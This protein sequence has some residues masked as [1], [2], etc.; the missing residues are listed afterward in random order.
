MNKEQVKELFEDVNFIRLIF[1]DVNGVLKNVEL[2]ISQLDKVLANEV[3]FDG[4]SI[5]GFTRIEESDMYLVPDL[6]TA[7]VMP[8]DL[9][10]GRKIGIMFCTAKTTDQKPFE[11]DP[12]NVLIRTL[13]RAK[14]LGFDVMV[15]PEPEF[16]LIKEDGEPND[17]GGYF[18][19]APLDLAANTRR[20]IVLA[21]EGLG[22]EVEAAHHEVASGQ[23]EV[24]FRYD[25]ALKTADNIQLFK[26]VVRNIAEINGRTATFMPKPF[27]GIN[28]S[29]MHCNISFM[30]DGKNAFV[31]E[32]EHLSET[33]KYFIGGILKNA[34]SLAAVTNPTVNSYKRLVPGYEAPVYAAWSGKNRSCMVRIPASGGNATRVEVRNPDPMANPYLALAVLIEAGLEGIE[35]KITPPQEERNNLYKMTTQEVRDMGIQVLPENL[36]EAIDEFKTSELAKRTF[37]E[38]LFHTFIKE[39]ES[40]WDQYRLS[41][42][43]WE[44]KRYL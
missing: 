9:E 10:G 18:D 2:S 12:R 6:N 28:G 22:F 17:Q 1:S 7:R 27:E 44:R 19:L 43:E 5:E 14:T 24:D 41:I 20:D 13:E 34:R 26:Y 25:E 37:G 16:F 36:K 30:K 29:G 35:N 3:M 40:E 8:W 11:G 23:H 32:T 38:H 33:A 39:K 4:S 21:L 42:S 31:G 15:G